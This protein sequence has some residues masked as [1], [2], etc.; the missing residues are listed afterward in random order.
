MRC[1][2]GICFAAVFAAAV[3]PVR[4]D[5]DAIGA[6]PAITNGGFWLTS[7]TNTDAGGDTTT[8]CGVGVISIPAGKRVTEIQ[9]VIG[10]RGPGGVGLID[11]GAVSDWRV[12]FWS[13]QAA[14]GASP[15]TGDVA[16]LHY[17]AP[18]NAG[19]A[20][21]YGVDSVGRPT[22]L[23]DF[24]LPGGINPSQSTDAY[25]AIRIVGSQTSLGSLGV[26]ESS[27]AGDSGLWA[28]ESL[29]PPGFV[30]FSSLGFHAH[31]GVFAYRVVAGC[32]ADFNGDGH[33]TV[34]DIF[35]FLAAWFAGR[36][37]A[38]FN[39]ASGVSIQDIFDFLSAWFGGC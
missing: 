16:S 38:N 6:G 19:F 21:P 5:F 36:P 23:V 8:A 32:A 29:G 22:F 10:T 18:T 20:T 35:D 13:S 33:V 17:S 34:Q 14:F 7:A 31:S 24:R 11:L 3:L 27:V 25:F 9:A 28:S 37:G 39:G 4:A 30:P 26:L 2:R 1:V 12:E 15:A